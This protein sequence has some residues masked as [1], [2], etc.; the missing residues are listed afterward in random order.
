MTLPID[1]FPYKNLNRFMFQ[2]SVEKGIKLK[3]PN[4]AE[5]QQNL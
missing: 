1:M 5:I 2:F 3:M 4:I